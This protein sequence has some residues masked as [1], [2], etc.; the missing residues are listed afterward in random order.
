MTACLVFILNPAEIKHS[1]S[2]NVILTMRKY[3]ITAK[4]TTANVARSHLFLSVA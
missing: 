3:G 2:L 4:S 1:H